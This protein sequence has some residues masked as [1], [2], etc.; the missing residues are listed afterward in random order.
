VMGSD[1]VVACELKVAMREEAYQ[2]NPVHPALAMISPMAMGKPAVP[3]LEAD[4]NF[5]LRLQLWVTRSGFGSQGSHAEGYGNVIGPPAQG[6]D[7]AHECPVR[8]PVGRNNTDV[9][10][11]R[12]VEKD[13]QLEILLREVGTRQQSVCVVDVG[14]KSAPYPVPAV[15]VRPVAP[16][17]P[18]TPSPQ[19]PTSS[20]GVPQP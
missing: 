11:A 14:M 17:A 20:S 6:F 9:Y 7:F 1:K 18:R 5:P 10:Q 12:W 13:L 3:V 19:A 2:L 8:L 4:P 16:A 15:G